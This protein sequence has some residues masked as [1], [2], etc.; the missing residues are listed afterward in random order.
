[1]ALQL[2]RDHS[3]F[4]E[5]LAEETKVS[6]ADARL[7]K[8]EWRTLKAMFM[9]GGRKCGAKKSSDARPFMTGEGSE[10]PTRQPQ[11]QPRVFQTQA[12][13]VQHMQKHVSR[14][15]LGQAKS[16]FRSGSGV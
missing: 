12:E 11:R 6:A 14:V 9:Q 3:A 15:E 2:D 1:M 7:P 16:P 4:L 8:A 10:D 5:R 13:V